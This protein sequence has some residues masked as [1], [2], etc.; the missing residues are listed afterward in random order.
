MAAVRIKMQLTPLREKKF[1][2]AVTPQVITGN[3]LST[4]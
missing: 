1:I 2:I 4:F 3:K